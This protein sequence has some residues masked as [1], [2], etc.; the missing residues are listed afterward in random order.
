MINLGQH[1]DNSRA[2]FG[3]FEHSLAQAKKFG[4]EHIEVGSYIGEYFITALGFE[5]SLNLWDDPLYYRKLADDAGIRFS[6]VDAASPMFEMAGS[7]RGIFYT[8]QAIRYAQELGAHSVDTTDRATGADFY[9]R[10]YAWDYGVRN[11]TELLKWAERHKIVINIETHGVY[12]QDPEFVE[13]FMK[14]FDS[15]WLGINFD[16]GNTYIAG[17]DPYEFL[18]EIYPYVRHM[19]IKDV[20]QALS[21]ESRG[22]ENGIPTSFIPIGKGCNANNIEKCL[23][24]MNEKGWNG[25]ISLE[26][27]GTDENVGASYRWIKEILED[28]AKSFWKA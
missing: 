16:T 8:T 26:C 3:T 22:D 11:Y 18:R 9:T 15:E 20:D 25:D 7:M 17:N 13:K 6:Q 12:T 10:E 28:S 21:D 4:M 23:R 5:P 1:A 24:F 2:V 14:Y 19:H 27:A